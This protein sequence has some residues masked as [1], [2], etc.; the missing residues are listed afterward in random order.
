IVEMWVEMDCPA[1]QAKVLKTLSRITGVHDVQIDGE[2]RKVSVIGWADQE[3]LLKTVRRKTGKKAELWP[4][5][6]P[7]PSDYYYHYGYE[8]WRQPTEMSAASR[9]LTTMFSDENPTACIV[10]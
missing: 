10:M 1:C 3:K 5:P 4:Y 2:T 6:Y 8:Y 7:Y 9:Q